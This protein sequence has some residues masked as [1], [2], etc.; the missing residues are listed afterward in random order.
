MKWKAVPY[1]A[2]AQGWGWASLLWPDSNA[3]GDGEVD[4]P[5]I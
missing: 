3:W 4:W 2:G 5:E 1:G